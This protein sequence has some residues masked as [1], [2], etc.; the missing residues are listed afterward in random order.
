[1][2]HE[3]A[4]I[5]HFSTLPSLMRRCEAYHFVPTPKL[6]IKSESELHEILRTNGERAQELQLHVAHYY[7]PDGPGRHNQSVPQTAF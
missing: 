1:M 7:L 2:G 6:E 4:T 5:E 3:K